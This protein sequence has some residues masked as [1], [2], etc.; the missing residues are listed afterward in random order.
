MDLEQLTLEIHGTESVFETKSSYLIAKMGFKA[1]NDL[2]DSDH[3]IFCYDTP[4]GS[5][6]TTIQCDT[7]FLERFLKEVGN[8][9]CLDLT[10]L[11]NKQSIGHLSFNRLFVRDLESLTIYLDNEAPNSLALATYLNHQGFEQVEARYIGLIDELRLDESYQVLAPWVASL[12]LTFL[13]TNSDELNLFN[14]YTIPK[15]SHDREYL[16]GVISRPLKE[17]YEQ[18][19]FEVIDSKSQLMKWC[20]WHETPNRSLVEDNYLKRLL[21]DNH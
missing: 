16:K 17:H 7:L 20:I 10:V 1:E 9:F 3:H 12:L 11:Y 2:T 21:A 6:A 5:M 4:D 14:L 13:Y 19:G 8:N 15:S 18:H